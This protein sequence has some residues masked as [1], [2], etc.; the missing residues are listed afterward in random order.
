MLSDKLT[1]NAQPKATMG[2]VFELLRGF[3]SNPWNIYE[4]GSLSTRKTILKTAFTATLAYDRERGFRT[5]QPSVI[6]ELFDKITSKCEMVPPHGQQ[7]TAIFPIKSEAMWTTIMVYRRSN[8]SITYNKFGPRL[9][10]NFSGLKIQGYGDKKSRSVDALLR[11]VR[12]PLFAIMYGFNISAF[13]SLSSLL[14]SRLILAS[15]RVFS[16]FQTAL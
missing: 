16:F 3:L 9:R 8:K 7:I 11:P 14:R 12:L 10:T 1:Q 5:P 15:Q 6:F 13:Q 4:N 2:E